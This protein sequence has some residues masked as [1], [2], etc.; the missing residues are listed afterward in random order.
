MGTQTYL[1]AANV[2]RQ[3]ND[4]NDPTGIAAKVFDNADFGYFKVN[5]ERPDRRSAQFRR[6]LIEPM[7]YEKSLREVIEH[8]YDVHG[9]S[10]YEK[11]YLKAN[12]KAI[13]SWC[14]DNDISLNTKS[15]TKL[16]DLDTWENGRLLVKLANQLAE[17]ITHEYNDF[18][19][20]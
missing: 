9:D 12:E 19:Q 6:H 11:G 14:E 7:R 3:L 5:I 16:F 15:K 20:F 1:D 18:N 17:A 4:N 8:I 2:E 10:V 13:L